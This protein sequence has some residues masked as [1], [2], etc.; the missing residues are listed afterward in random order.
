MKKIVGLCALALFITIGGIGCG[1]DPTGAGTGKSKDMEK[2]E[3][4][5]KEK[6][7]KEGRE[8]DPIKEKMMKKTP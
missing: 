4:D 3:T 8:S 2:L 6:F 1:S 7:M 5:M